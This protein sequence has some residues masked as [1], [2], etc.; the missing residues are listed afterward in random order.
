MDLN[1][2]TFR[3]KNGITPGLKSPDVLNT[4]QNDVK[5]TGVDNEN[6]TFFFNPTT[7]TRTTIYNNRQLIITQNFR[8]KITKLL[9]VGLFMSIISPKTVKALGG[10]AIKS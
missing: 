9:S 7:I 5:P 10:L 4:L 1:P 3:F 6:S 8:D 2:L